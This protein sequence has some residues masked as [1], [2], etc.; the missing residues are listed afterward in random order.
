MQALAGAVGRDSM[1]DDSFDDPPA[2]PPPPPGPVMSSYIPATPSY[3][4]PLPALPAAPE[5][6]VQAAPAPAPVHDGPSWTRPWTLGEMRNN[7]SDWTLA[8]DSGLLN[9]LKEF[10]SKMMQRTTDLNRQVGGL[11]ADTQRANVQLLNTVNEF[12]L[13]SNTQFIES[14]VWGENE[15]IKKEEEKKPEAAAAAA[16][17]SESAASGGDAIDQRYREAIGLGVAAMALTSF[18]R[19]PKAPVAVAAP[20]E[21]ADGA[22]E[23]AA[24]ADDSESEDEHDRF[25]R[26]P[27]PFVIGTEEFDEDDRVG[28]FDPERSDE[29]KAE[30]TMQPGDDDDDDEEEED[31]SYELAMPRVPQP[32]GMGDVHAVEAVGAPDGASE[33]YV[34]QQQSDEQQRPQSQHFPGEGEQPPLAPPAPADM[35]GVGPPRTLAD[36]LAS[37]LG[38]AP[39]PADPV[40][41][42]SAVPV[43]EEDAAPAAASSD[44]FAAAA[45]SNAWGASLFEENVPA[46]VDIFAPSAK[47]MFDTESIFSDAAGAPPV[48]I[49]SATADDLFGTAAP[50]R[51][52][53][54]RAAA[55]SVVA[56]VVA[57]PPPAAAAVAAPKS[58][59]DDIF[60]G[61]IFGDAP[62]VAAAAAKRLAAASA[63][64]D[65][66]FGAQPAAG[67][68][69]GNDIF[70]SFSVAAPAPA[71][72]A[73]V[74]AARPPAP[75]VVAPV[76]TAPSP[77]PAAA[78]EAPV[79]AA[80][81]TTPVQAAGPKR[82][83]GAVSLFGGVDMFSGASPGTP[84]L[85]RQSRTASTGSRSAT[86][87]NV[88]EELPPSIVEPG[89]SAPAPAPAPAGP[90]RPAGAVS[91][92]G[93]VDLFG[94]SCCVFERTRAR[95]EGASRRV[96]GVVWRV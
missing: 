18:G 81:A 91:M 1:E 96:F 80:V 46:P 79:A 83:V 87:A 20:P 43:V 76:I 88:V 73:A 66:I 56:A 93:G 9:F 82:P 12:L 60:G 94:F 32:A 70:G 21:G 85:S 45:P 26:R 65:D 48:D 77:V 50:K 5:G 63:Y 35:G 10:G 25:N 62:P 44:P 49:F 41:L 15:G 68:P 29:E 36:E 84:S 72:A 6:E 75:A 30:A 2:P 27:L 28:L 4:Q 14:R 38:V 54:P 31:D 92:F 52:E 58:A 90:K 40:A 69:N 74:V 42:P 47:G 33:Q 37:R 78:V 67:G 89:S 59:V 57:A 53:P 24:P 55:P 13:L 7:S 8:C 95:Q 39:R 71:A 17:G 22:A 3:D 19:Q 23:S 34:Q 61:S 86:P 51:S 16:P 11:V 64:D